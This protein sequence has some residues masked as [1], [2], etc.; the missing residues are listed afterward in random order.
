M[1]KNDSHTD[2]KK[3]K[4][5]HFSIKFQDSFYTFF[6]SPFSEN[7]EIIE[8]SSVIRIFMC[9]V[10]HPGVLCWFLVSVYVRHFSY[11]QFTVHSLEQHVSVQ[12]GHRQVQ[13][14]VYMSSHWGSYFFL[15]MSRN[16]R[17]FF[18]M[19]ATLNRNMF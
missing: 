1:R 9:V 12:C 4:A 10:Y 8:F 6:F 18:L 7:Y 2:V 15:P 3:L 13:F 11:T 19:M 5:V 14:P 16:G 17:E